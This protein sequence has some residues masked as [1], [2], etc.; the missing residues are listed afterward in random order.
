[1][2]RELLTGK[3]TAGYTQKE[4]KRGK[5]GGR[6]AGQRTDPCPI[7]FCLSVWKQTT[8]GLFRAQCGISLLLNFMLR[9]TDLSLLF[10]WRGQMT[11]HNTN[12]KSRD[13][14]LSAFLCHVCDE[15]QKVSP[16]K[17]LLINSLPFTTFTGPGVFYGSI[18]KDGIQIREM[19]HASNYLGHRVFRGTVK[20][21]ENGIVIKGRFFF[22][23]WEIFCFAMLL[24]L[25]YFA[26]RG[27]A[28][29][30]LLFSLV[31]C[32]VCFSISWLTSFQCERDLV[33][34]LSELGN[35]W[36]NT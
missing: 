25:A 2:R 22:R 18:T 21:D 13:A 15:S 4:D 20:E 9:L 32:I 16:K 8:K 26:W 1:M 31:G 6:N 33:I 3:G 11:I 5:S 36:D 7:R 10:W 35:P 29:S 14:F 23:W 28:L 24:F 30:S 17:Q 12:I 27:R 19:R 34:F